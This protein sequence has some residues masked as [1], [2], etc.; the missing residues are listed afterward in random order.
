[1]PDKPKAMFA[2]RESESTYIWYVDELWKRTEG[3]PIKD[4][5]IES[6]G[7]LD[8]DEWFGDHSTPTIRDVSLR[9]KRIMAANLDY[10]II[11]SPDGG[12]LDG[13]HRIAK[14]WILGH[15]RISAIQFEVMP[16]PDKILSNP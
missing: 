5:E 13:S 10:P 7:I 8:H 15:D 1:M 14:V 6:L 11:L 2:R 16:S 12:V 4:V 9:C 3:L